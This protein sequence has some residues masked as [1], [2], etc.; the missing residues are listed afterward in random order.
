MSSPTQ[1]ATKK[2]KKAKKATSESK[3]DAGSLKRKLEEVEAVSTIDA[4]AAKKKRKKEKREKKK[5]AAAAAA[6]SK[7]A[8][9]VD[10]GVQITKKER[11]KLKKDKK[12]A[13]VAAVPFVRKKNSGGG[14]QKDF[15]SIHP[16]V[17]SRSSADVRSIPASRV[18]FW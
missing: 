2:V 18:H 14:I 15:Y 4:A 1:A 9:P 6:T 5:A 8:A 17:A 16:A 11:K 13:G 10:G 7:A 3:A 12:A